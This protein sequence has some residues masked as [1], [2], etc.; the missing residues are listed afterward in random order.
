MKQT[1]TLLCATL[2]CLFGLNQTVSAAKDPT[3]ER[4]LIT[5]LRSEAAPAEKA[6]ACKRL[7]I[8]G[9]QEAVPVLAP[10]LA[11][12]RLASWARI[13]LEVIPGPAADEALRQAVPKLG[14]MLLV[15]TINSIGVRRDAQAVDILLPKLGDP[16]S[17][18]ASAAAVALGRIGGTRPAK[19]LGAAL[20]KSPESVRPAVADGCIRCAERFLAEGKASNAVK[21][22]D[23]VRKAA[24]PKQKV[25]DATRGAILARKAKGIPL[26][27]EQL[28]SPDKALLS[29]GLSTAREL[30][31][32]EVTKAITSELHRASADRQPLLLLA[33][34]DR[35][36]PAVMPVV[37]EC[38]DSPS[39]PL[40]LTAVRVLDRI[41]TAAC[42]PALESAAMS[43]DSEIS[44]AAIAVLARLAGA[45]IDSQ[46]L[47]RL[48]QAT[49]KARCVLVDV[50]G[51]RGL[52]AAIPIMLRSAED[53]DAEVRAGSLQ[54][55]GAIGGNR[56]LPELVQLLRKSQGEKD[57]TGIE[58]AMLAICARGGAGSVADVKALAQ[59]PDNRVRLV[60]LHLLA[61]AGGADA[62]AAVK[63]AIADK[64]VSVQ[65]E[66]V[67]TLSSWPNTWPEDEAV[68]EPLL[69]VAR[70]S[71]KTSH[72]VLALRGYFQFLDGD[73]KLKSD[74]KVARVREVLPLLQR[75]E[76]K[77]LAITVIR[78]A[79]SDGAL[80]V[81]ST[82]VTDPT[83]SDDA[84][85]AAVELAGRNQAGLSK[86]MRQKA[87]QAVAEKS[88]S[89]E[90]KKRADEALKKL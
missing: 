12:E 75:P 73:K 24:V 45:E 27:V 53:T 9:S 85:S 82:F 34:A 70:T 31:G 11:D 1:T 56:Q 4:E 43:G 10:L 79:P 87:L 81:V 48:S 38:A 20:A 16:D 25:L 7:A 41:G 59:D 61:A 2:V 65:D 55:L 60:S 5:L 13:A 6:L 89:E 36:D 33:L 14:G 52:E 78:K 30:P 57:R 26:L 44:Q 29:I 46:I 23:G 3:K 15:G 50:A 64:D 51:R 63:G 35:S 83:V 72:Q 39:K 74:D 58:Q 19:A 68:L 47:Q 37:L 66:A 76:E 18:V 8:Y 62:L 21:L 32:S 77:R 71:S 88:T 80:E 90:L 84:S 28:R 86:D 69:G 54:A 17:Q 67:R 42:I 22:Y 40:R 49:G